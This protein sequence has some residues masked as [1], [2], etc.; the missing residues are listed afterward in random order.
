MDEFDAFL[1]C[2]IL[3]HGFLR[4]RCSGCG[5][6][7]LVALSCKRRG[8]CPSYGARRMAATAACLFDSTGEATY[9]MPGCRRPTE[10]IAFLP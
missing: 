3:V 9:L 10:A 6:E 7:K 4:L 8:I 2:G 5:H 1:E